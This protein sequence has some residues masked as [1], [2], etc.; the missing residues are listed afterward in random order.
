MARSLEWRL[1]RE[2]IYRRFHRDSAGLST[3][4]EKDVKR[5]KELLIKYFPKRFGPGGKQ[6]LNARGYDNLQIGALF[7]YLLTYA[8]KYV[9]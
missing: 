7:N 1:R 4:F 2:E 5:K 9:G 8:G 6:D 3:S